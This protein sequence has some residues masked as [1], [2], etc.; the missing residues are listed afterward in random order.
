M[1][2]FFHLVKLTA[3]FYFVAC[4]AG[5]FTKPRFYSPNSATRWAK[6]AQSD[7]HVVIIS[8][9]SMEVKTLRQNPLQHV[10]NS[11]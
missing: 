11:A 9:L 3:V 6:L 2:N 1:F 7:D 8:S 4:L 5:L 10:T